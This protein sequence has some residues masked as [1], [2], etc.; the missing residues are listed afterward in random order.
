M[1]RISDLRN[2]DII[3]NSDG[4]KLGYIRDI[5]FDIQKGQVKSFILT[6]DKGFRGWF[7]RP[8]EIVIEWSQIKKIGVDV[9]LVELNERLA[10]EKDQRQQKMPVAHDV[11][12]IEEDNFDEWQ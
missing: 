6:Y 7:N 2:K 1:M 8:E 5:E 9:I 3:N 4:K 10:D 12:I 11:E